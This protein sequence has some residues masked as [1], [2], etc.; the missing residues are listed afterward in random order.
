MAVAKKFMAELKNAKPVKRAYRKNPTPKFGGAEK[1]TKE[2]SRQITAA[3]K[4]YKNFSGHEP[5][6]VGKTSKPKI[7]SVGIVIGELDGVAYETVRDGKTE[8]YFHQFNKRIRPLL[9]S[10]FDGASI[11]ILGG[12]YDFTQDGIVDGND[13]KYSPR[14]KG[15]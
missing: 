3:M 15:K 10:S 11:Y 4:L 14:M 6:L 13:A 5:E 8:K 12:E 7:P 9:V 1:A 2:L